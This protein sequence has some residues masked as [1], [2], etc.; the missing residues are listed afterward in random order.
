[1][2]GTAR[3]AAPRSPRPG[4][5]AFCQIR[6]RRFRRSGRRAPA[7][8]RLGAAVFEAR[9]GGHCGRQR[10]L[11]PSHESLARDGGDLNSLV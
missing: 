9:H 10:G 8:A 4:L 6:S 3:W 11:A 7:R 1:M 2:S 5:S